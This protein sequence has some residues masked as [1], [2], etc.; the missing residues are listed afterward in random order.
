MAKRKKKEAP[1][2]VESFG[3]KLIARNKRASF[4]Y[5]LEGRYEAGM[6]LIGSEVKMLRHGTADLS[7]AFCRIEKGEAWLY[8][9]NIPEMSG[10]HYGHEAK[11][12][13]KLLLNRHEIDQIQRAIDR[14][15]IA[16]L[17]ALLQSSAKDR[18]AS[19][20]QK[21]SV[22]LKKTADVFSG[23]Q[24]DAMDAMSSGQSTASSR[25]IIVERSGLS[26]VCP[27]PLERSGLS[28]AV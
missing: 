3:D 26:W 16:K 20:F 25:V 10:T 28:W 2:P 5:E 27:G 11:R 8:G 22:K 17:A 7:D 21:K 4:D 9:V 14:D 19:E 6:V 23:K 24:M 18:S 15:G 12:R 1:P 13:R